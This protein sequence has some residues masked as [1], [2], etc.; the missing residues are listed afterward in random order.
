MDFGIVG[1][2]AMGGA[3]ARC[4]V[5][6]GYTV[7]GIDPEEAAVTRAK[8]TGIVI[9]KDL[10][11]LS[12]SAQTVVTCLPTPDAVVATFEMFNQTTPPQGQIV[13]DTSTVSPQIAMLAGSISTNS[14]RRHLEAS[15]IGLPAVAEVG[16]LFLFLGGDVKT[17]TECA[18]FLDTVAR[19]HVHLG[20]VGAAAKA[21]VLNN[22]IGNANM[23]VFTEAIVAAEQLGLDPDFF[24]EAVCN[25]DGAGMSKVFARHAHWATGS[26]QPQ[27]STPINLKDMKMLTEMLGDLR[28]QTAILGQAAQICENLDTQAGM[29]RAYSD[30]LRNK[31]RGGW[32]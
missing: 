1:L 31:A 27:P 29:V 9:T 15:M 25:A 2:G 22:A 11:E 10:C 30:N 24:V 5:R 21:K 6:A 23:L 13:I 20:G 17:V 4:L 7:C 3:M 26:G 32:N 18:P 14:G 12:Q 8:A 16:N 19:G 28:K